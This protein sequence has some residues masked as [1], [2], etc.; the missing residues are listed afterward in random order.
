MN[1]HTRLTAVLEPTEYNIKIMS[2]IQRYFEYNR[3]IIF[4]AKT[5]K[6]VKQHCFKIEKHIFKLL[7]R[8]YTL[9]GYEVVGFSKS[10]I[11]NGKYVSGYQYAVIYDSSP[12]V[13]KHITV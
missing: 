2:Y 6:K 10:P 12:L 3:K 4:N 11:Y 8:K 5:R 7:R 1:T 9:T 13:I